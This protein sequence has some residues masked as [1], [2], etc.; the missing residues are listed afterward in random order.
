MSLPLPE[1][2]PFSEK[3]VAPAELTLLSDPEYTTANGLKSSDSLSS[4]TADDDRTPPSVLALSRGYQ[5]I[6]MA[7]ISLAASAPQLASA[8]LGEAAT[9]IRPESRRQEDLAKAQTLGE[10]A[11]ARS[12]ELGLTRREFQML[13]FIALG[14]SNKDIAEKEWI[15]E[16]TVKFHLSNIYGKLGVKTRTEAAAF[17]YSEGLLVNGEDDVYEQK[18]E[19]GLTYGEYEVLTLVAKGLSN[20]AIAET[21]GTT[22]QTTKFHTSNIFRKLGAN[23]RTEAARLFNEKR[24]IIASRK[25]MVAKSARP[26]IIKILDEFVGQQ[27]SYTEIGRLLYPDEQV[28]DATLR[29]RAAYYLRPSNIDATL[30]GS[31]IE[32]DR[33]KN[34]DKEIVLIPRRINGSQSS[35]NGDLLGPLD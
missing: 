27:I 21:L 6:R 11:V 16:Q 14:L 33:I 26:K 8:H 3:S 15:T 20:S 19:Y 25:Q 30:K 2:D 13:G 18:E 12:I 10:M 4:S 22:E 24:V 29:K 32:I 23:N 35:D 9:L 31:G 1:A 17:A 28:D 7:M 34:Y 5:H